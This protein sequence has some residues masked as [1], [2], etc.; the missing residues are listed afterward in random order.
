MIFPCIKV[1]QSRTWRTAPAV[2][3]SSRLGTSRGSKG[4]TTYRIEIEYQYQVDGKTWYGKQYDFFSSMHTN[5][6]VKGMREAVNKNPI[7]AKIEC[8]YNPAQPS[9]SVISSDIPGRVFFFALFAFIFSL[10]GILCF[11]VFLKSSSKEETPKEMT[12]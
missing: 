11:S 6:G 3:I 12:P 9:E 1:W 7:G 8:L 4:G 5:V 10:P 2:V